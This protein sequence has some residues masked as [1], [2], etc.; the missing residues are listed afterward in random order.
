MAWKNKLPLKER[1]LRSIS[2]EPNTGCWLWCGFVPDGGYGRFRM[3]SNPKKAST[4]AHRAAWLLFV[5]RIPRG[6]L[7]CHKCDVRACANPDHLFLGSYA[8]NM[9]DASRKGRMDWK[10]AKRPGLRRGE[11]HPAAKL[12]ASDV[13]FIRG[14]EETGVRLAEQFGVAPLTI[15]RIRRNLIWRHI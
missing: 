13:I 15:S 10:I 4:P 12:R 7:V 2:P 11:A 14:S 5:G 3:C 1:F 8:D 9:R 6:T